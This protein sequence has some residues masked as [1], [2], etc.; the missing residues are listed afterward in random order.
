MAEAMQKNEGMSIIKDVLESFDCC[1]FTTF[2][3]RIYAKKKSEFTIIEG[4][5]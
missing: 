5:P 2:V 3:I 4:H 1:E